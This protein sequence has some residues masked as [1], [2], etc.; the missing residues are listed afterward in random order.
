[1][2]TK[3]GEGLN[4]LNFKPSEGLVVHKKLVH[5]KEHK[6]TFILLQCV[7]QSGLECLLG[8]VNRKVCKKYSIKTII[9]NWLRIINTVK[10]LC[11][12]SNA[13]NRCINEVAIK[14]VQKTFKHSVID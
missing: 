5:F 2:K 8:Y 7:Q 9:Q 3:R 12:K 6:I 11:H 1:M 4:H 10:K 14:F 13:K